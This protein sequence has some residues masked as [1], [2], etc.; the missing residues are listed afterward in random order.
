MGYASTSM[1]YLNDLWKYNPIT[2]QWTWVKGDNTTEQYSVYG[3]KGHANN[4]N[5]PGA[6]YSS[7]SWTD[8]NSNLWL[9]GGFGYTHN[10]FGF[11]NSLWKYDPATNQWTWIKG[12]NTIDKIGVY[13]TQGI[14]D[15]N[16]KPGARYGSQTWIDASGNL[17]LYGGYGFTAGSFGLMNDL[18]KY[19]PVTNQWTWVNGDNTV[20]QLGVYG[21]K[22]VA[23]ATNKPGA[24][25]ISTSW[26]D[27]TGNLWMFGGYGYDETNPGNLGDLWKY[28]IAANEWTWVE[29]EKIIDQPGI[30][31]TQGISTNIT[32]PGARYVSSA[33]TDNNGNLWLFG[34][35]GQDEA[36]NSGYLNDLWRYHPATNRW[37]W[38]KGDK[39]VDQLGV[40]GTQG[41]AA[42]TNKSGARTASLSWTDG[43]GNL[44]LFGGYGYDGS[45]T[46]VLND[47]W[48]ITNL[49]GVLPVHLLQFSG[50]INNAAVQLQWESEQETSFSHFNIQRSL[51]GI[52]FTTIGKINANGNNNRNNY[53]YTDNEIKNQQV[54]KA[55]YRLQLMD[56]N[57]SNTYSKVLTFNFNKAITGITT[58]PNP[59]IQS[60][61]ISFTNSKAGAISISI[62]DMRGV[63]VKKQTEN[64]SSGIASLNIDINNLASGTYIAVLTNAEG[65]LV[66]QKFIKQ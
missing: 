54:S 43:M 29:G 53:N 17:W 11:L 40:Y 3:T 19:N 51:D 56:K 2:N 50:S 61:N 58:F 44:W 45:T 14:A 38:V 28:N 36:G 57:G 52:N 6:I 30:Y 65:V 60:L 48:K 9:F 4:S 21:T 24:R 15:N 62:N 25:Y 7:V 32:Q 27:N 23:N 16:N 46:G 42:F 5:K 64:I 13:G 31:G 10:D 8:K 35:S 66:Q 12:D 63:V 41:Q 39:T 34:G 49:F 47:L 55:F 20:E 1:G 59:A 26:A 37:T 33:W 18:W 22:G